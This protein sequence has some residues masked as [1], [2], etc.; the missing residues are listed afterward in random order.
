MPTTATLANIARE[1]PPMTGCGMAATMAAA[2]GSRPRKIM[3]TPAAVTTQRDFTRVRRTRPTFCAK[4]VYGKEFRTPPSRVD[5]PSARRALAMSRGAIR[6]PTTSPVAKTSPVVSTAVT[7]M[8]MI[9]A[10]SAVAEN[11]G[12]PK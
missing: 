9:M 2:L 6:L 8:T 12:M 10:R 11:F 5:R 3:K 4:Q 1:A 7:A